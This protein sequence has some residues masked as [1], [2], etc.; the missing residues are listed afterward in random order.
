MTDY[1]DPI[2]AYVENCHTCTGRSRGL[3]EGYPYLLVMSVVHVICRNDK[4]NVPKS[5]ERRVL[6]LPV[7]R[8]RTAHA[9]QYMSCVK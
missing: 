7:N 3:G 8:V 9:Y 2:N 6:V 5:L 4:E 1:V